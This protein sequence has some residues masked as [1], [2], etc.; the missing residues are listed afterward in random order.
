MDALDSWHARE[1]VDAVRG[2]AST[3]TIDE[4]VDIVRQAARRLTGAD[5]ASFVLRDGNMCRYVDE[6]AIAPLWKGKRFPMETCISG[7]VMEHGE[8]VT[9]EDIYADERIPADAYRPTFVHSMVMVPIRTVAPVGAIGTYW[10]ETRVARPVEVELLQALA[11]STAVAME[12]V[13]LY[14]Q[15]EARVAHRTAELEQANEELRVLTAAVAHDIRSPLTALR[16]FADL[17]IDHYGDEMGDGARTAATTVRRTAHN[18]TRL[19]SDL[20]D[21]VDSNATHELRFE[22]ILVASMVADVE[23]RV[24]ADAEARR[25]RIDVVGVDRLVADR[26]LLARA[27]QNIVANA[28]A[29]IP[30]D[31]H[32]FIEVSLRR[33]VD[34]YDLCVA[35]NGDGIPADERE[36]VLQP[37]QRGSAAPR[38]LGSG[39]GLGLAL[40]QRVAS[41]H[42]G[43]LSIGDA[44]GGGAVIELRLPVREPSAR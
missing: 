35:D 32:P 10:A 44:P 27:L 4:I 23:E 37:F 33:D 1:L 7:W 2:L 5:G 13:G 39:N 34:W 25:A 14:E 3:R 6:D 29:Y 40:C 30:A 26:V 38:R 42:G 22:E 41:E 43:S 8:A 18:L 24:S 11:D 19:V 9:L 12:N 15:L 36:A 28:L 21:Y 16:G 31:R 20:L 17:L